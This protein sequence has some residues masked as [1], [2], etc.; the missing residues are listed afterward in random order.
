MEKEEE[1]VVSSVTFVL[2]EWHGSF[3]TKFQSKVLSSVG[4]GARKYKAVG[5]NC[6][7]DIM[8]G[9]SK[10]GDPIEDV[11]AVD[12]KD[13]AGGQSSNQ[14]ELSELGDHMSLHISVPLCNC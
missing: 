14:Q 5:S 11:V 3:M 13:C 8:V 2:T 4:K 9:M 12:G 7:A 6:D 1:N 10:F